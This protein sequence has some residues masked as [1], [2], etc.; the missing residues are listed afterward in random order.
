MK[1]KALYFLGAMSALYLVSFAAFHIRNDKVKK[2][3]AVGMGASALLG[4]GAATL[5]DTIQGAE[6]LQNDGFYTVH[7]FR[8]R[9]NTAAHDAN[10]IDELED[11]LNLDELEDAPKCEFSK[12]RLN[13]GSRGK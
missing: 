11:D 9:K 4:V 8:S 10:D 3:A 13:H 5:A 6:D 2:V 7:T 12:N 1:N